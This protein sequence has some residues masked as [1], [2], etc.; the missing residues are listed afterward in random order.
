MLSKRVI[1]VLLLKNN[2]LVK[3]VQ[4]KNPVY[5]G[6]PINAVKLFNDKEVDELAFLDI[7]ASKNGKEPNYKLIEQIAGEAFMPVSYGG[8]VNSVEQVRQL[9]KIG[10]E[11]VI[12]NSNNFSDANLLAQLADRFGSSTVVACVDIKKNLFGKAELYSHNATKSQKGNVLEFCKE[13]ERRGAGELLVNNIDRD[14]K[15]NG[16]DVPLLKEISSA[17][18]IPVIACGGAGNMQHIKELHQK[19]NVAAFA[20][21][22]IFVFHGPHKA[23]LINYPTQHE[24]A[25]LLKPSA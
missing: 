17:L 15:M 10:I 5:V 4:F 12:V 20:A 7:E 19:T 1:P 9:I 21:G 11:K 18:S 16:Y 24:L 14:G 23:V 6:D 2:G 13:L 25:D 8:N 22:S 3:T